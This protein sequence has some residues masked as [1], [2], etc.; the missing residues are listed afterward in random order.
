MNEV[1]IDTDI[2]SLFLRNDPRVTSHADSY[3][4]SRTGFTLSIITSFEILRGLEVKNASRQLIKF[5]HIRQLSR[6]LNL[7]GD[8]VTKAANIYAE[9]YRNGMLIGDADILIAATALQNSLPIVTNNE[10][11]FGRVSGLRIL[12][13]AV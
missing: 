3:L 7:T 12:N 5:E 11:H 6:E 10:S 13:W 9:L 8:I 2:L 4:K 1:V